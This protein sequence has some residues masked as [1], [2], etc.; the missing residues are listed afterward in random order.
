M[1]VKGISTTASVLS[2]E[3]VEHLYKVAMVNK[4]Y[5]LCKVIVGGAYYGLHIEQTLSLRWSDVLSDVF[6]VGAKKGKIITVRNT[7]EAKK[8]IFELM[9]VCGSVDTDD[10]FIITRFGGKAS[11]QCINRQLKNLNFYSKLFIKNLSTESFRKA[12]G[13]H[14][15]DS[16]PYRMKESGLSMIA[17]YF[18]QQSLHVTVEYLGLKDRFFE[19]DNPF[20]MFEFIEK[21]SDNTG[22]PEEFARQFRK[23]GFVYL[24][25]DSALPTLVKI[26]K[27]CQL[28]DREGTLQ[29]EKPTYSLYK[30]VRLDCE[31]AA[32]AFETSLHKRYK[33]YR[34]R[35]EW[36]E[37]PKGQMN[38]LLEEFSWNDYSDKKEH[39]FNNN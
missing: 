33:E 23:P 34:R 14:V 6:F 17:E 39:K 22:V 16:L 20:E 3:D 24:L 21:E 5:S 9:N 31:K 19:F 2:W 29:G 26:G 12:F 13:R 8:K 38:A 4:M 27:T 37:I 35:G 7:K 18:G 25:K 28:S 1:S 11:S 36:F 10:Y 15:Y 30:Y 32:Y